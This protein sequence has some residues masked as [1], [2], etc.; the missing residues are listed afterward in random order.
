MVAKLV[1][2]LQ[3]SMG[4]HYGIEVCAIKIRS[5]LCQIDVAA[6][7]DA[8]V[9]YFPFHDGWRR[10]KEGRGHAGRISPCL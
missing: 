6:K 2:S 8:I 9:S 7:A 5:C 3:L 1:C 10:H 4:C